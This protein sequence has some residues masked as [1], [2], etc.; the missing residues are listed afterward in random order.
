MFCPSQEYINDIHWPCSDVYPIACVAFHL[1]WSQP[2]HNCCHQGLH[3]R[4]NPVR[5]GEL[6]A[7]APRASAGKPQKI[8]VIPANMCTKSAVS[9]HRAFAAPRATLNSQHAHARL[10]QCLCGCA[11]SLSACCN[12]R[13]VQRFPTNAFILQKC[14]GGDA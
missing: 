10:L 11:Y 9:P 2:S 3:A 4:N 1:D 8:E 13:K 7:N 5:G 12:C 6:V 14:V